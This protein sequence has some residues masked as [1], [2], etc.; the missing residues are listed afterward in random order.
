MR[1]LL[2]AAA[3]LILAWAAVVWAGIPAVARRVGL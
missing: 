1:R 3:C 2:I